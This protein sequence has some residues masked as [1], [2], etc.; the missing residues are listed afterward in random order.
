MWT[1]EAPLTRGQLLSKR[2]DFWETS[3]LYGGRQEIW[4]VCKTTEAFCTDG[5]YHKPQ[6]SKQYQNVFSPHIYKLTAPAIPQ[7]VVLSSR[8]INATTFSIMIPV[9]RICAGFSQA[10]RAAAESEDIA[11]AQAIVDA[12]NVT[13]A[14]QYPFLHQQ[15]L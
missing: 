9:P 2:D 3:P 1:S 7:H 13:C 10:L 12:I 8:I 11:T 4:Q 5:L 15:F 6:P 14:P